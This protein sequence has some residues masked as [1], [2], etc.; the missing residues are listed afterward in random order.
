[1]AAQISH[2][3]FDLNYSLIG[4]LISSFRCLFIPLFAQSYIL[5]YIVIL[6]LRRKPPKNAILGYTR[7]R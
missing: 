4:V 3:L 6:V 2:G 5:R 1:M 7:F